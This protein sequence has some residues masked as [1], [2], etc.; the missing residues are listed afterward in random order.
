L[1]SQLKSHFNFKLFLFP[2][3]GDR[4]IF[5]GIF[6]YYISSILMKKIP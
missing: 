1:Q 4:P 6:F 2:L 5:R 3:I